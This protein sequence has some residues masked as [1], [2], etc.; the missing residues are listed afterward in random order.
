VNRIRK[1]NSTRNPQPN[2]ISNEVAG[3]V[4]L[5]QSTI[6]TGAVR[7]FDTTATVAPVSLTLL[8]KTMMAPESIEYFVNGKTILEN[9]LNGLAPSVLAASSISTLILSNAA[10]MD[11]TKYGYVMDKCAKIKTNI[12]GIKGKLPFQKKLSETPSAIDGTI[13]GMFT[14]MS[15]TAE[16]DLPSFLLAIK[17]AIGKPMKKPRTVTIAP[18]P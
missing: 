10:D 5:T 12:S 15:R 4:P 9:T 7:R 18:R 8:V 16:V 6:T 2:P 17:I 13:S 1:E 3:T 14:R 11:L